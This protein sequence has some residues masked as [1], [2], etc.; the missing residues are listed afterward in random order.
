[1][2]LKNIGESKK[3]KV[4]MLL[5]VALVFTLIIFRAGVLVGYRKAAFSYRFGENYYQSFVGDR[6]GPFHAFFGRDLPGG[7]GAVGKIV[8][9]SLPNLVVVGS[10]NIEKVV[11]VDTD[12]AIR[13]F[14][15]SI[16]ATDLRVG[17]FV[18][19]LG[20]PDDKGEVMAKLIRVMPAPGMM[21]SS[22]TAI[23]SSSPNY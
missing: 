23:I 16:S 7:S 9:I 8:R 11:V 19:V 3:F 4:V 5:I 6:P 17:D 12:V 14:R 22:S 1:M 18:V 20:S 2:D 10:D 15:D 13:R 21:A